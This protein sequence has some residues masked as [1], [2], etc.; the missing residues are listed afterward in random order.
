MLHGV[1]GRQGQVCI[2]DVCN[3]V[4]MQ[5]C[6]GASV[7]RVLFVAIVWCYVWGVL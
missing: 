2:R 3:E 1:L 7:L 5:W 4:V 6:S